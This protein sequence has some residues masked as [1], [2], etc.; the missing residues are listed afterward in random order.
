L[1]EFEAGGFSV[2]VWQIGRRGGKTLLACIL[3]LFDVALRDDLRRFLRPSEI[4]VAALIAPRLES[5][6]E[7]IKTCRALVEQSPQLRSLLVA[8]T[9][10]ELT[11]ANQSAIRAFPCSSR[12]IRGQAWS[13]CVTDEIGHYTTTEDQNGDRT[14]D[15][16]LAAAQPSLA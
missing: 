4:R 5:A 1:A 11:F 13:S 10:D 2:A 12:G 8:E 3:V 9:A 6:R 15:E 16:I 7:L 14:G